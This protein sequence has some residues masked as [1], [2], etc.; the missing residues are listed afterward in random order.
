MTLHGDLSTLELADIVQNLELHKRSGTLAVETALG[1]TRVY[2]DRGAVA[3]IASERRPAMLDD[4]VLAGLVT[5]KQLE[6]ARK[7]RWRTRKAL[8]EVLVKRKALDGDTLRWFAERRLQEDLCDFLALEAGAFTFTDEGVPRNVFDPEERNVGLALPVGAM[9]FEA[10]RR[11]D[12]WPLIRRRLPSDATHYLAP[13]SLEVE[14][15]GDQELARAVV[16]RLDGTRSV[17]EVV[18]RSRTAASRPTSC[19]CA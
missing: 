5:E 16:A 17:R 2:F 9:L 14:G 6:G 19:S 18:R 13:E 1:T 7:A 10:A 4:L 15:A 11:K 8:G 3:M 12:H